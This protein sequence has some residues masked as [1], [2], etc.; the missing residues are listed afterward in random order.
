[1]RRVLAAVLLSACVEYPV[2]THPE[3][4]NIFKTWDLDA[5]RLA[6]FTHDGVVIHPGF[7]QG[8]ARVGLSFLGK[9]A[10]TVTVEKVGVTGIG[11]SETIEVEPK[12]TVELAE[13]KRHPGFFTEH[14][15]VPFP[16]PPEGV[17]AMGAEGIVVNVQWRVA[18][19]APTQTKLLLPRRM[20]RDIA[21]PT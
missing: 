21:W 9:Q 1:M 13:S 6:Q 20:A 15:D 2:Y 4:H 8:H 18:D 16:P 17:D 10:S 11:G 14:L 5:P 3:T 7:T 12:T 19:G